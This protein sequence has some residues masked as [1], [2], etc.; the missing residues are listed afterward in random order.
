MQGE[1][2]HS[3]L[4]G[5]SQLG[6]NHHSAIGI[7]ALTHLNSREAHLCVPPSGIQEPGQ[8]TQCAEVQLIEPRM[9]VEALQWRKLI[10]MNRNESSCSSRRSNRATGTCRT[11]RSR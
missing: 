10:E 5:F 6:C 11:P 3:T 2:V 9:D 8:T 1:I 4:Q 7:V